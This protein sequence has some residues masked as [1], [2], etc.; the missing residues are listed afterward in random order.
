VPDNAP[1]YPNT[2]YG[3]YKQANEQSAR[4]YWQDWGL[5]S[6]G[7]RPHIVY[8][9]GRDQG[10]TSGIAKAVLAAAA[11]H[12][13][14]IKFD[15]LVALQYAADVARIFIAA[16]RTEYQGATVCNLRN[17]VVEVSDFVE[18]LQAEVPASHI[19]YT[20]N[21]PLLFPAN[22]DD[23]GLRQILGTIPHTALKTAIPQMLAQF[24]TLLAEE[25]IDLRQLEE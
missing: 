7:L 10:L 14:E 13:Y 15:G 6:I 21:H 24:R 19:S 18:M 2:L 5:G 17:D 20:S 9:V 3:V 23:S 16:A 22:L 25:R 4:I 8:G 1:L 11:Q 12:P